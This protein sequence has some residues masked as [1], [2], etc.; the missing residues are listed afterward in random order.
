MK[1]YKILLSRPKESF[2]QLS[3]DQ[4]DQFW[5]S[6][7]EKLIELGGRRLLTCDCRWSTEEWKVF[8][9]TEYPD[10]ESAQKHTEALEELGAYHYFEGIT[11]LGTPREKYQ[12][13]KWEI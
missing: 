6:M 11:Y 7:T 4:Q 9:I 2:F 1:V 3:K 13:I 8:S 10:L 5:K 12:D